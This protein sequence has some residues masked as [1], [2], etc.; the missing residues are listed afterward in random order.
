M[1]SY[2]QIQN[3]GL[4]MVADK[5]PATTGADTITSLNLLKNMFPEGD[6]RR[7][8]VEKIQKTEAKYILAGISA[9]TS[10]PNRGVLSELLGGSG[11]QHAVVAG[12]LIKDMDAKQAYERTL[13]NALANDVRD[14]LGFERNDVRAAALNNLINRP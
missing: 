2:D 1:A 5:A 10:G 12:Q 3:M 6:P 14:N 13:R 7:L 11:F 4:K 9:L 8:E